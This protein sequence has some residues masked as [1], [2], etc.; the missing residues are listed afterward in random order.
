MSECPIEMVVEMV[1]SAEPHRR[2]PPDKGASPNFHGILTSDNTRRPQSWIKQTSVEGSG[3]SARRFL[4]TMQKEMT[5]SDRRRMLRF[6]FL[7]IF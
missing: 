1:E 2:R 4:G 3:P 6:A 7:Q 5:T